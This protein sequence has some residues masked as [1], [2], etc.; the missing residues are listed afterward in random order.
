VSDRKDLLLEFV[1]AVARHSALRGDTVAALLDAARRNLEIGTGTPEVAFAATTLV[2]EDLLVAHEIG[3]AQA[4]HQAGLSTV[5]PEAADPVAAFLQGT[6]PTT[7]LID[8]TG[9][10]WLL[11]QGVAGPLAALRLTSPSGGWDDAGAA[12]GHATAVGDELG[13]GLVRHWV[14]QQVLDRSGALLEA[15][16]HTHVG[17]FEWDIVADKVRWSD[18]LFRI[19]GYEPQSFEPTFE[20][21]LERIHDDDRDAVRASVYQAYEQKR[22]YRIEER[23]VRPDGSSRQLTSWGHVI[24]DEHTVPIKIIGS[25]QDVTDSR[26]ALL[27]L[28]ETERRLAEVQER[29]ARAMELNDNVVQGLAAALYALELG[30]SD[31][32][33]T[34]LSGTLRSA[35]AIV[36]DLLT[37]SGE[38]LAEVGL[39]RREPAHAFLLPAPV[40]RHVAP[41]PTAT[42]IVIADDSDDIRW[43]TSMI[44][45]GE[46]DFEVV[47]E[48]TNG[49]EA[50]AEVQ[51]HQP[52][53]VL[54]DLAMPVLDGLGAI[55][56][57]RAAS[58]ETII[59]VFSGFNAGSAAQEA[60]D[61]GAHA[62]VEKGIIDVSLATVLRGIRGR[63]VTDPPLV[64]G[65]DV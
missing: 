18:E 29:R 65:S 10:A 41:A 64:A 62:Y 48:A 49:L 19:F 45:A 1:R 2:G 5:A 24:V 63:A 56:Q 57:I 31:E 36:G 27:R 60:L 61:R 8:E 37:S 3:L 34:E 55:L 46:E 54:L 53:M 39:L 44:L 51:A 14:E 33:T 16:R 38:D 21:F 28:A 40:V 30:L 26:A 43:L 6:T 22:D 32:A 52:D 23:I 35:R 50:I 25:C 42:R 20:E 17:C 59:V 15:Q 58:P 9:A 47:A 4:A 7:S 11:L 13:R 12:L